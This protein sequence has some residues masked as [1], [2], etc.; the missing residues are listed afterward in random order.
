[1]L[2]DVV[3]DG[4]ADAAGLRPGDVIVGLNGRPV[5]DNNQLTR[6]VGVIPPGNSVKLDVVRDG[7]E[8][9]FDVKLAPRPDESEESGRSRGGQGRGE[10]GEGDLLGLMVE[11]LSP[12]MSRRAQ[13][14]PGTKGAVVVDVAADSPGADAG[15][16]PGD[17]VV[18]VNR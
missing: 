11:D 15:F 4:P 17:V 10:K 13:V 5:N 1:L 14:E 2:A 9:N 12:Q 7:K 8:K 18:E 3:K 6:D 16:E